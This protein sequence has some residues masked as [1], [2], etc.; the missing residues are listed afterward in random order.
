MPT[1]PD[2]HDPRA[3]LPAVSRY[4][5]AAHLVQAAYSGRLRSTPGALACTDRG[6]F[7]P[8]PFK[9]GGGGHAERLPWRWRGLALERGGGDDREL[10]DVLLGAERHPI[11]LS[12]IRLATDAAYAT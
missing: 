2:G 1:I 12:S 6:R 5:P 11:K 8:K 7:H 9:V 4:C 3:A 10:G